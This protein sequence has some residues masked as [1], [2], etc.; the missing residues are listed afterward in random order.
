MSKIACLGLLLLGAASVSH[1]QERKS[2]ADVSL[3]RL[4]EESQRIA[5]NADFDLVWWIPPEFWEVSF[6]QDATMTPSGV[7]TFMES[8]RG[9][10]I[11]GV[12]QADV[13]PFGSFV[14]ADREVVRKGLSV[15]FLPDDGRPRH[16]SPIETLEPDLELLLSQI[17]PI[18]S[19][20]MGSAGE[21]FH[22]FVFSDIGDGS[23]VER[24]VSPYDSGELAIMLAGRTPDSPLEFVIELPMDSLFVPRT[25]PNGK[26]AHVSWSYCPWDGS[27][28]AGD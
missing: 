21:N 25:C 23:D 19:A 9:I 8:L 12:I 22:F 15:S 1:G 28:L 17:T 5:D 6:L 14:F 10:S 2:L 3:G 16:L 4:T 26:A 18:L 7:A 20:A 11:V 13:S 27:R 24:L